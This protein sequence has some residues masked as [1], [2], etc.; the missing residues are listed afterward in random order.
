[1]QI[2]SVIISSFRETFAP[3]ADPVKWPDESVT[4]ALNEA[5]TATGGSGWGQYEDLPQ[6]F[7]R[8]G[9]FYYAAHWLTSFYGVNGSNPAKV[10]PTSRLNTSA[11]SVGDESVQYRITIMENTAND[12]LGTTIYGQMFWPLKRRAGMGARTV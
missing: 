8:R 11:K 12:W 7:K 9:L 6:N 1:M 10:D 4:L 5:A 3:F 2:T